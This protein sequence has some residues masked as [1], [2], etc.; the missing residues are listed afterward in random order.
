MLAD[1]SVLLS[2]LVAGVVTAVLI[3]VMLRMRARLPLD[4]P[5]DRSL[6]SVP[7]PRTGGVAVL[8]GALTGAIGALMMTSYVDGFPKWP[9]LLALGVAVPSFVDDYRGLGP[10]W[11]L[12]LHFAA[13]GVFVFA[14]LPE[15]PLWLQVILVA[16]TVWV[17]NLYNFMDG[18]DGLAG[19]MTL[20][21]FACLSAAAGIAGDMPLALA[22]ASVAGGA[23]GF[24]FFNF[25][26]AKIFMG[27]A[28]SVP[29]GFLAAAFGITGWVRGHWELWFPLMIFSPFV[30]DASVTLLKRI[31]RGERV[32]QAHR[33]HYYQRLVRMGWSH[34]RLALTEYAL[35]AGAGLSALVM[36]DIALAPQWAALGIWLVIYLALMAIV[37]RQ[38]KRF[39]ACEGAA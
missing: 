25:S 17:T 32:W 19:G 29:L 21:G 28:G 10:L 39:M 22:C 4:H 12:L 6:H 11:R 15:Q 3:A 34:R 24:L 20:I 1:V 18:A 2:P 14:V 33:D 8:A 23:I 36:R 5:N 9:G 16:V 13:A 31:L 30:A 7:V 38:W 26:P 37:D 35:M 27:D